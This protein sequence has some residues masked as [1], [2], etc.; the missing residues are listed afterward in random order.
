MCDKFI[1]TDA[2][3]LSEDYK[4]Q[5]LVNNCNRYFFHTVCTYWQLFIDLSE[6]NNTFSIISFTKDFSL[7][8]CLFWALVHSCFI[9]GEV[10]S[11]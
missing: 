11:C 6:R 3:V 1:F 5:A 7:M 9:K 8:T 10:S 2:K 4:L